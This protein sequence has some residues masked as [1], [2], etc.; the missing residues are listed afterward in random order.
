MREKEKLKRN[1][2]ALLLFLIVLQIFA[3]FLTYNFISLQIGVSQ[4]APFG[5]A[6]VGQA[7]LNALSLLIPVICFTLFFIIF[8]KFFGKKFFMLITVIISIAIVFFLNP[9]YM[10]SLLANYLSPSSSYVLSYLITFVLMSFVIYSFIKFNPWMSNITTFIISAELGS[11]FAIM[12]SPPTL[13]II[14]LAFLLYD[15]YAVFFGPLKIFIKELRK[16]ERRVKIKKEERRGLNLGVLIANVGGFSIGSGDLFFYS[17]LVSAAF[18][19]GGIFGTLTVMIAV[20]FGVLINLVLLVKYKKMLPGLPIP[21]ALG[22]V[23]LLFFW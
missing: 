18:I 5:N 20:N 15:I 22:L 16:G 17:L 11:L 3:V 12:L 1:L 9:L 13:F 7:G 4:Y 2:P 14:P 19:L 23:V 10:F 8:L 6:T 21:L